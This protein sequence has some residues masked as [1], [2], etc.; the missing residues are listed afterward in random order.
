[1]AYIQIINQFVYISQIDT[2]IEIMTFY[3]LLTVAGTVSLA[4]GGNYN[5]KDRLSYSEDK[6]DR[7]Y[8]SKR[9][10]SD[11]YDDSGRPSGYGHAYS[12]DP[13]ERTYGKAYSYDPYER[14]YGSAYSMRYD[15]Y[16]RTYGS[17][18]SMHKDDDDKHYDDDGDY[19]SSK[20]W[21]TPSYPSKDSKGWKK[22]SDKYDT[23]NHMIRM[24]E[25]MVRHIQ[26]MIIKKI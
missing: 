12:R 1:M 24:R 18:Y 19:R 13:Y 17:A 25:S 11:K 9:W 5:T 10:A 15:P 7:D 8:P 22:D 16:G 2:L 23:H 20:Q 6:H 21:K 3:S 4:F 26:R 14:T